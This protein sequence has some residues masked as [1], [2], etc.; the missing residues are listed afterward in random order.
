V[1]ESDFA[2]ETAFSAAS[3]ALLQGRSMESVLAD[4][5]D[6]ADQLREL[7][8]TVAAVRAVAHPQLTPAAQAAIQRR[9][10]AALEPAAPAPAIAQRRGARPIAPSRPPR[11]FARF[12][13]AAFAGV[14]TLLLL[15]VIAGVLLFGVFAAPRSAKTRQVASYTGIITAMTAT[16]W[17]VDDTEVLIDEATEIHGVPAVGAE[18]RCIGEEL[19]GER[20]RAF[21]VWIEALAP[22]APRPDNHRPAPP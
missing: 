9:V 21:E 2:R 18:M 3:Q 11:I 6:D 10:L 20:M 13:P 16:V 7:L 14:A 22:T 8:A 1:F 19:P 4:Y 12:S 15:G 17:L 5:P